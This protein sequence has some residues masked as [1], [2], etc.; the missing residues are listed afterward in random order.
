MNFA[1]K[2]QTVTYIIPYTTDHLELAQC[3]MLCHLIVKLRLIQ[4]LLEPQRISVNIHF[5]QF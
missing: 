1:K 2:A 3:Y 4:K 5:N